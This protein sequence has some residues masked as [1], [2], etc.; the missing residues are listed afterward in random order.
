MDWTVEDAMRV[1]ENTES[2]SLFAEAVSDLHDCVGV[3][4]CVIANAVN[5]IHK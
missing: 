3:C 4:V 1:T 5:E 2:A